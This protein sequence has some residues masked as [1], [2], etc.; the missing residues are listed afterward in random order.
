MPNA[1]VRRRPREVGN[2]ESR[3]GPLSAPRR[4]NAVR[5]TTTDGPELTNRRPCG[6]RARR[7]GATRPQKPPAPERAAGSRRRRQ[8]GHDSLPGDAA[9]GAD[10]ADPDLR[11]RDRRH[12]LADDALRTRTWSR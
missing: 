6:R 3:Y 8:A 5:T 4:S 11:R 1:A 10:L 9:L 2:L 7:S 12:H